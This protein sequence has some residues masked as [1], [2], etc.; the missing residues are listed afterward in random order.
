[1]ATAEI[2]KE[3]KS[4]VSKHLMMVT[5]M[6]TTTLKAVATTT[7][8]DGEGSFINRIHYSILNLGC[9]RGG[10]VAFVLGR[11]TER[12]KSGSW[13]AERKEEVISRL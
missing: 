7:T 4:L 8:H 11:I 3:L 9:W 1:M 5:T 10:A 2:W 12:K 13:F 6:D